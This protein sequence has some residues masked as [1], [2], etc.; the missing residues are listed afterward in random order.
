MKINILPQRLEIFQ[1]I[2]YTLIHFEEVKNVN[3]I[4]QGKCVKKLN[5]ISTVKLIYIMYLNIIIV[6]NA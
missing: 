3:V 4:T 6:I 1:N 2:I 5:L